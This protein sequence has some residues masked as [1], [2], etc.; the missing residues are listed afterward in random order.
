MQL[1]I[2]ELSLQGQYNS[3]HDFEQAITQFLIMLG[4]I[5]DSIKENSMFK[6]EVII[7]REGL[8]KT[9]FSSSL[10]QIRNKDIKERFRRVFY[11]KSNPKNWQDNQLHNEN[12]VYIC[13][14]CTEND[15][16]VSNT[17]LAE[18]TERQLQE[19]QKKHILLNF[20]SSVFSNHQS[21]EVTKSEKD[22]VQL[23]HFEQRDTF[24]K[25]F[26]RLP[27]R[28][29]DWFLQQEVFFIKITGKHCKG[30]QIYKEISTG[31]YWYLDTLHKNELEVFDKGGKH[32]GT[33]DLEGNR[34]P[35]SK[36]EGRTIDI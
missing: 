31:Y 19:P 18:A 20:C 14:V 3:N 5:N 7:H 6:S 12:D 10:E 30:A 36:V 13:Q 35:N 1:F 16:L 28:P 15:G 23:I 32:L 21:V 2:N 8:A 24:E 11:N 17:T 22:C 26:N 9:H 27:R 25:W 29:L 34:Q 33:S 4:H